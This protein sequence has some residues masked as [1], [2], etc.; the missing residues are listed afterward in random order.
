MERH[1]YC[2]V[3][4]DLPIPRGGGGM[5]RKPTIEQVGGFVTIHVAMPP[6]AM[7]HAVKL[8][9]AKGRQDLSAVM[10]A[11]IDCLCVCLAAADMPC[12]S[13]AVC[14]AISDCLTIQ[15]PP[16]THHHPLS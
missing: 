16:Q 9:K 5:K 13:F 11:G 3:S 8:A 7:K 2:A 6:K 12:M 14:I 10:A 1:G 15:V 4:S